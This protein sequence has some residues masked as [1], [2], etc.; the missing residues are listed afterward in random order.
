MQSKLRVNVIGY[1]FDKSN[2]L[3]DKRST[4]ISNIETSVANSTG[5]TGLVEDIVLNKVQTDKGEL[6]NFSVVNCEFGL[7]YLYNMVEP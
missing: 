3:A 1:L 6:E 4:L 2:N 7:D 5:V